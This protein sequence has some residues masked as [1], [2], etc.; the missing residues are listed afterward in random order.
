MIKLSQ[1]GDD[2]LKAICYIADKY[3]ESVQIKDI[4][5]SQWMSESCLRLIIPELRK[6]G[7]IETKQGRNGGLTLAK[8]STRISLYDIFVAINEEIGIT[9]CTKGIECERQSNCYTTDVLGNL[10]RGFH[11]L[12][13]MQ[14]IDKIIKK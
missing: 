12:L 2:A 9:D 3:P 6:A 5:L 14:T 8:E 11:S 13:K 1:N 10:Q 4:S 7:I